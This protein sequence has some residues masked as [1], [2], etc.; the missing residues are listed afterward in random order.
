[1]KIRNLSMLRASGLIA[2]TALLHAC[3]SGSGASTSENPITAAPDASSYSGPP[4]A[5]ADIQAFKIFVWDNLSPDNRCG[6]CHDEDQTPRFARSDDINL[7]YAEINTVVDLTDP[8]SSLLVT[9]VAGGHNCWLPNDADCGARI[10]SY[11]DNWASD[12]LGSGGKEVELEAP[13]LNDPGSSKNFPVDSVDFAATVYPLLTTYCSECHTDSAAV[14]Q[15]PFFASGEIDTAYSAAQARMDLD[16]PENSRF[17][18]R[19]GEEFHNCWDDDCQASASEMQTAITAFSDSIALTE[20][21]ED[22]VTSKA[23]RLTD[24]IVASSGGRYESNVIALYEFKRGTGNT[25]LDT[26]GIEPALD[27]T[28]SGTY[29][30]VG[31]WGVQFVAGK[32][33]GSTT[34]S[35]KLRDLISATGEYSIE[36]WVAPANVTQDGPARIVT[37]SGGSTSRNL[38]LGQTL[39][40]YDAFIRTDQ[41]DQ[42]GEPALSTADADEDLQATLQHVVVTYDPVNGRRIYVNGVFT[43]D[44]DPIPGGLLND[45]DD[46][47]AFALGSEVDNDSRWAGTIRLLAMH[48]RAMTP[49]QIVQNFEVGVGEKYF[50]LFNLSDHVGINDAYIVFEVSQFDNYSY[51]FD[52]PFFVILDAAETPGDIPVEGIRIGLNG[53]EVSVGQAFA[54]V[55]I[56]ITDAEY[57]AEGLQKI[58]NM[59]TI[60]PLEKGPSLDEFFLTFELLGTTA[61]A[62]VEA[63][64]TAPPPPL[65]LPRDPEL[66]VRDFAEI[67]ATMS[68]MTG[69]SVANSAVAATYD[70]VHQAMPVGTGISGFISSQQMGITQLAI[71]YCSVLV[72]DTSARASYFPDFPFGT[73]HTTAF[74]D[75]SS[76]L[77]PLLTN[78]VGRGISTQP[79]ETALRAELNSLVDTLAACSSCESDRTERIVKAACASV[80]GSAAML[81]Q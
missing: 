7:A 23:L 28:L 41:T 30:W 25:V 21:D 76:L 3:G 4:P 71:K 61:N 77:D 54:N 56:N 80:L 18:N 62:F 48:N 63:T 22:L 13:T 5:T 20:L 44:S 59:G 16:T 8:G 52:E 69:I 53:R 66:G 58:S 81:V 15:S 47:F 73:S 68:R 40:N 46:T 32:A 65:D 17:V 27:L 11:L 36:A 24:G 67:H 51:L 9:N 55:D 6:S 75:R 38:M 35:A 37:Y 64:P 78:M 39:Y 70:L 43:D 33:Q 31:G 74:N 42:N 45:W 26:S 34:A 14:P 2:I 57:A 49:A 19:L 60:I 29:N 50:L 10:E 1:M 12:S 79:E 72:D